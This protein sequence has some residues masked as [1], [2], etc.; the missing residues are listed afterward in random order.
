MPNTFRL[1][2]SPQKTPRPDTFRPK[3][4]PLSTLKAF[5]SAARHGSFARAGV[6][7]NVSAAAISHQVKLL[8]QMLGIALF[9][10]EARGVT[11]TPAGASYRDDIT[12]A[13]N[14]IGRAT[15]NLVRAPVQGPLRVSVAH[16]FAQH[17]LTPRMGSLLR[18]YP[19]LQLS[20]RSDNQL[21]DIHGG[22]ADVAIRFGMG[23]YP[24]LHSEFFLSDS[25][26]ILVATGLLESSKDTDNR[27]LLLHSTLLD[28]DS[29]SAAEPWMSWT[30]WLREA[31]VKTE[32]LQRRIR[33]SDSAMTVNACLSGAGLCIGRLS[34]VLDALR[35]RQLTP[36]LP[37]RSTEFAH[38]IV[39]RESDADNPRLRAFID[40]LLREGELFAAEAEIATGQV[41]R[42]G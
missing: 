36:L 13:L 9:V 19:D 28:D 10:R 26:T 23:H 18:Q 39:Y 42:R 20:I 6:E 40:W 33:F 2:A 29:I 31:G 11:L 32:S 14:L 3:T 27:H 17:W 7:L 1:K 41:L 15:E 5:E 35:R 37:W 8:E 24:G 22:E 16:S 38:H 21:S 4:P 34:L 12:Q 30:P 25:A